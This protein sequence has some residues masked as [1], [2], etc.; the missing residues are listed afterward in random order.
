LK[1]V[2]NPAK[3]ARHLT[4]DAKG[5][6]RMSHSPSTFG[7]EAA[8]EPGID[9]DDAATLHR[10]GDAGLLSGLT[11]VRKGS[12][13]DLVRYFA[14]LPVDDRGGYVIERTG[15]HRLEAA[16]IMELYA[17]PDFPHAQG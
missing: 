13:A 9:W 17:R 14:L 15:D 10:A 7:G 8:R 11:G 3:A 2:A 5:Y 16:E 12:L 1:P 6:L 4:A